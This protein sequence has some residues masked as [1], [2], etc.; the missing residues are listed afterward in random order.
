V[1]LIIAGPGVRAG[2]VSHFPARLVDLA[3]TVLRLLGVPY[4]QLDGVALADAFTDPLPK[5][6]AAQAAVARYLIPVAE[7]LRRQSHLEVRSAVGPPK[8]KQTNQSNGPIT[9]EPSY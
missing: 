2:H 9:V 3:P 6:K 5:E 4:P 1:P 7:T 8:P